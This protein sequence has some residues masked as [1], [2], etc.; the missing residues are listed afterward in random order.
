MRP[1]TLVAVMGI[2]VQASTAV[3]QSA[4]RDLPDLYRPGGP[5]VTVTITL[6]DVGAVAAAGLEDKPPSGWTVSNISNGGSFDVSSGKVKWGPFFSPSIPG[7][8]SYDVL[9]SPT[10][11]GE[12]C[13]AGTASFDGLDEAVGGELCIPAPVPAASAWG[14]LAMVLGVLSAATMVIRSRVGLRLT[15]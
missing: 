15:D 4:N 11:S 12:A 10:S 7:A 13:F 6:N 2:L 14:L 3:A 9:P 8:L 5:M 1:S